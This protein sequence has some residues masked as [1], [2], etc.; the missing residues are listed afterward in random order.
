M[1]VKY[2]VLFVDD[3]GVRWRAEID[4]PSYPAGASPIELTGVGREFCNIEYGDTSENP[5]DPVIG[6]TV[7]LR[8]YNRTGEI[9]VKE[10]QLLKDLEARVLIYRGTSLYWSGFV[11]PDGIGEELRPYPNTVTLTA[12][13]GLLTLD[14][15][16]FYIAGYWSMPPG[17]SNRSPLSYIRS[18][19][20]GT[21]HLNNPLPIRWTSRVGSARYC[22]DAFAGQTWWGNYGEAW[23][24]PG[25]ENKTCL[26]ILREMLSAFRMRIYQVKGEWVI[27]R[28]NDVATGQ[29]F[30]RRITEPK[31]T[32]V[33]DYSEGVD[34]LLVS[35]AFVGDNHYVTVLPALTGIEMTY[36]A[37]VR[38]NTIPN[39]S[40]ETWVFG[41]AVTDWSLK[42]PTGAA[43]VMVEP[44]GQSLNDRPGES[45]RLLFPILGTNQ[46][47]NAYFELEGRLPIDAHY[48]YKEF[49]FGFTFMPE[50]GFPFFI[51]GPNEGFIDWESNPLQFSITYEA[52]RNAGQNPVRL[53]LN[54][55]GY[56]QRLPLSPIL[57]MVASTGDPHNKTLTFSGRPTA[58]Q[59]TIIEYEWVTGGVTSRVGGTYKVE[60]SEE[61]NLTQYVSKVRQALI[62]D[63]TVPAPGYWT[64]G[65]TGNVIT[66]QSSV[67]ANVFQVTLTLNTGL[68]GLTPDGFI[69]VK[70]DQMKMGDIATYQ[71]RGRGGFTGAVFPDP[72][73]MYPETAFPDRGTFM[74]QFKLKEGQSYVLDEVFMTIPSA[75]DTYLS[76][77][78]PGETRQTN[79]EK[80]TLQISSSPTGFH[81]T[82]LMESFFTSKLDSIYYDG[83]WAGTL[84][85]LAANATM[86]VKC[87]PRE[88]F[89]GDI[90]VRRGEGDP[91]GAWR[92]NSIYVMGEGKNLLN[93]SRYE[94]NSESPD[95]NETFAP[96]IYPLGQSLEEGKEYTLSGWSSTDNGGD[97]MAISLVNG[98]TVVAVLEPGRVNK[99]NNFTFFE[100]AFEASAAMVSAD[101]VRIDVDQTLFPGNGGTTYTKNLMLN[102]GLGALGWTPSKTEK[103]GKN[104]LPLNSRYNVETGFVNIT[105]MEIT[106]E[107]INLTEKH[108]GED[109]FIR[110]RVTCAPLF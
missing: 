18:V 70:V 97:M 50:K 14:S 11:I 89:T 104:Y 26:W 36:D 59:S 49:N 56:W 22:D 15:M 57:N 21:S 85:S 60:V 69:R 6:S 29:I 1:A 77:L 16:P 109:V 52:P 74:V 64:V 31:G 10:L 98:N 110:P 61:D 35:P 53:H 105:C 5:F 79:I 80:E 101:N 93:D 62:N 86:R 66:I 83:K 87:K 24:Q 47:R 68:D 91:L 107:T 46:N 20:G 63:L 81:M 54:E 27:E 48:L 103:P 84:T 30:W 9:D 43:F 45:A 13:D 65:G 37:D 32:S 38:E 2:R 96:I 67:S 92:F 75:T 33:P 82:N 76:S 44:Y 42:I 3:S 100:I 94:R 51:S 7:T 95:P 41:I 40:F 4:M 88:V 106:D 28:V 23:K 8:M 19:L 34:D 90:L 39:G 102:E 99:E 17:I 73:E 108:N 72:G 58:G 12:T 55:F 78:P 71:F 25:A